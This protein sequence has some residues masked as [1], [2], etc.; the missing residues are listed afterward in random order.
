[1]TGSIPFL[2]EGDLIEIVAPAKA[3]S[4]EI[5]YMARDLCE[6]RGFQV[7]LSQNCMGSYHYFSGTIEERKNDF[8]SALWNPEVKAVLCARGGY[9]CVQ[10]LGELDW[11][12]LIDNPKWIVGFSDV[13]VFHQH[14]NKMGLPSIHATMPLNFNDNSTEA[15]DTLFNALCGHFPNIVYPSSVD[16][17][18]GTGRGLLVGGNLSIIYSLIGTPSQPDYS[19]KILFIED[20]SEQLYHLDRIFYTLR[21]SGILNQIS[22]IV[23]GGMT[24][25]KDTDVPFGKTYREIISEHLKDR[26]IPIAFDF[27]AGHINDNRALVLGTYVS[28]EVDHSEVRLVYL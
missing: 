12:G 27:P 17:K 11:S 9:G 26:S 21:F 23:I 6:E 7:K 4:S 15:I 18:F 14:L 5:V 22:G 28:L 20:L 16:N 25:M 3:I 1:M 8:Q 13:T 24:E 19:D 10:Y 2:K